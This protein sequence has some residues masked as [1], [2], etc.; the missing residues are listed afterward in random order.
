[1]SRLVRIPADVER[2]DRLLAGLTA[3]QLLVLALAGLGAGF[4]V[5]IAR[6]VLP[7]PLALG[8]AGPVA[9]AGLVLT[10]AR[11]HGLPGDRFALAV[12]DY[13][14]SPRQQVPAPA[15]VAPA[16]PWATGAVDL[17][18]PL[19]LPAKDLYSNGT[20]DLGPDG[21]SLVCRASAIN[22]RLRNE[23]EQEAAIAAF[24]RF[25]NGLS[26][27]VQIIVRSQRA[28]LRTLVAQ[29]RQRA[30]GLPHPALEGAALAHARFLERLTARRDVLR[31]ELLLVLR[32]PTGGD[33]AAVLPH[34]AEQAAALL[35]A[36]GI[37]LTALDHDAAADLLTRA[38]NPDGPPRAAGLAAPGQ[39][40]TRR[41]S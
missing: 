18:A 35:A 13:L 9:V 29:L 15:G 11:V 39:T 32:E 25:L 20:I 36:A 40:I 6:R 33:P 21:A 14:R 17:P 22:F 4:I 27:P 1:V 5:T 10:L 2:E 34:R 24:A 31:R 23:E 28:D 37:T 3:R 38:A 12:L 16:P 8:L 7:L 19:T 30:G 41:P 26:T